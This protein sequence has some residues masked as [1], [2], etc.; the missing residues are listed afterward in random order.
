MKLFLLFSVC[1]FALKVS[2]MTIFEDKHICNLHTHLTL[3]I[4]SLGTANQYLLTRMDQVY[5]RYCRHFV[6]VIIF[7]IH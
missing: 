7:C 3:K 1:C 5:V 4:D 6:S 2:F